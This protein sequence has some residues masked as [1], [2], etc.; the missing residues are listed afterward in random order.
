[1]SCESLLRYEWLEA[2]L[3]YRLVVVR[4]IVFTPNISDMPQRML[5]DF[6]VVSSI[7][8]RT[9]QSIMYLPTSYEYFA[10]KFQSIS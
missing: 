6:Y 10:K 2:D 7:N 3:D 5:D 9:D 1:M 8:E 4:S